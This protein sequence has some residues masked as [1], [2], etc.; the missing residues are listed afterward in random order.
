M[1][2]SEMH[3]I[4][5]N[6]LNMQRIGHRKEKLKEIC[7]LVGGGGDSVAII[8]KV[9]SFMFWYYTQEDLPCAA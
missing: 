6:Y 3:T 5:M 1:P 9:L 2:L 4:C 7:I 8:Q